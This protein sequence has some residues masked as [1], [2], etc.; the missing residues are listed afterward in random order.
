M[1]RTAFLFSGQGAQVPGMMK[2]IT[3]SIPEAEQV[4]TIADN[5]LKRSIS[6][7]CFE[8]PQEELNLTHNTQPCVLAADLAAWSAVYKAGITPDVVAGFSLGEYAALVA[9]GVLNI[10]DVFPLIQKR[11]DFMQQAVPVGQGAMAAIMKLS[12][13]EVEKLCEEVSGYVIPVNYNC[14][15]QIVVSG[16]AQAVDNLILRAKEKKSRCLKLPVSAP[17]HCEL[18]APAAE[19]L[20]KE[21]AALPFCYS[22]IPVYM[23]VDGY[24]EQE[25]EAIRGKIYLQ[26]KSPVMWEKT[27]RNMYDDDIRIFIELGPGKTLSGFVKRTLSD[28]DDI[29]I[30]NVTDSESLCATIE[31]LKGIT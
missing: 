20:R 21:I 1:R 18:M 3:K 27:L 8:G 28:K 24:P 7:L 12:S 2:D 19:L 23:N 31:I 15:G 22:K 26:T 6:K 16:E 11:A 13:E 29:M 5:S 14:P 9:S 30:L 25:P 17:F 10:E 4:F